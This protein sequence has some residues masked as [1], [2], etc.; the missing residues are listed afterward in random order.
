MS[1]PFTCTP[2][3][4]CLPRLHAKDYELKRPLLSQIQSS[5]VIVQVGSMLWYAQNRDV[6]GVV[7]YSLIVCKDE[8]RYS[9]LRSAVS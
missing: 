9:K 5:T 4:V 8:S 3:F 6:T 1:C 2:V 7:W